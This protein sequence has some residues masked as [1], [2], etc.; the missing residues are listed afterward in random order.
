[1]VW[2]MRSRWHGIR[3]NYVAK[4][5]LTTDEWVRRLNALADKLAEYENMTHPSSWK[6]LNADLMQQWREIA[7][8]PVYDPPKQL[9]LGL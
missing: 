1:M 7:A 6:E 2:D 9:E 5:T 8:T 4:K 3:N